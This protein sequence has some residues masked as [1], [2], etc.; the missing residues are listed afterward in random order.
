M[1]GADPREASRLR[2][3]RID[4]ADEHL[5]DL[6]RRL[7]ATRWPDEGPRSDWRLG[8]PL[9]YMRD[10]VRYWETH[11]DW[12]AQERR[13]N[14]F[15]QHVATPGGV[16]VHFVYER[17]EQPGA[18]AVL[19]LHGWPSSFW[20]FHQVIEPLASGRAAGGV[21]AHVVVPSLPGYVFSHRAFQRRFGIVDCAELL[22][23][24]MT[25][26]LGYE[27]FVVAGGDWGAYVAAAMAHR[28][29]DAVAAL[30]LNM[31]PLRRDPGWPA[32]PTPEEREYLAALETWQ[33]EEAGYSLLQGT[34]PQT[35]A[36]ALSDSPVGL[37]A[38]IL[39]KFA[40]WSDS[41]ADPD[42]CFGRDDL[43]T[44]VMLYWLTGSIGSS[45]W[46]Y[47]TR[48]HGEWTVNDLAGAGARID[49]PTYYIDF[50]K[51]N[52]RPPRTIAERL[53]NIQSWVSADAGGHYPALEQ[54]A[55]FSRSVAR[56]LLAAAA[57]R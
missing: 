47:Y 43:I 49:V 57:S 30:H 31:L 20:E 51:E 16:D 55:V 54:P 45:F 32:S 12:R 34:R 21:G 56:C 26:V 9:A 18:V 22:T 38:W 44:T 24:L 37:A 6:R 8:A 10:L 19:L 13:M 28:R 39:E 11:F 41:G 15:R 27:R 2:D 1:S 3:F 52:I 40:L 7:R 5:S 53:F 14:A 23:E 33:R 50:P 29:R 17:A 25:T 35:P 4:V 48:H 46:P 42:R 36:Y